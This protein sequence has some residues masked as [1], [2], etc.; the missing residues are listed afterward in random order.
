VALPPVVH[1]AFLGIDDRLRSNSSGSD[2]ERGDTASIIAMVASVTLTLGIL[3]KGQRE[4]QNRDRGEHMS[5]EQRYTTSASSKRK[6]CSRNEMESW[7][8][9][10]CHRRCDLE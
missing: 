2:A 8:C 1:T 3:A 9:G 6:L 4:K 7:I 5:R 10:P